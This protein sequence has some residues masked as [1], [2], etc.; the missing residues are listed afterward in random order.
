MVIV[1]QLY[2]WCF[3]R[4]TDSIEDI[5][6]WL[7]KSGFPTVRVLDVT[8]DNMHS[9][10]DAIGQEVAGGVPIVV[11]NLCDGLE[12]D[13]YPGLTVVQ[14]LERKGVKFTGATAEFF[15]NTTAKTTMKH[16][17]T[18]K[19]VPTS[20]YLEYTSSTQASDFDTLGGYP[21]IVKPSVSYSSLSIT[22]ASVVWD[23]ASALA[24]AKAVEKEV[25]EGGVF[26]ERFLAGR[27]F[28]ALVLG[29]AQN[30]FHCCPVVERVFEDSLG[31]Y[32]RFLAF[33]R[34][35]DGYTIESTAPTHEKHLYHY[36]LA[37]AELQVE[38]QR[39]AI[40]A[41]AALG[42][43]SYG[44][45]DMRTDTPEAESIFV[46][47]VNSQPAFSFERKS[48]SMAEILHLAELSPTQFL[49]TLIKDAWNR[50]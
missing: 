14:Q 17:F 36:A 16:A 44:R 5:A 37:P 39:V 22:D 34:Y 30:G 20:P 49:T 1:I 23:G 8:L 10:C 24:Q 9:V 48:S 41:Y 2:L 50:K 45:I 25:M 31:T 3:T 43:T 7:K 29:D 18:V 28:T 21:L 40:L 46:L 26:V 33:N 11:L 42:G 35:W 47:E 27:E 19:S 15:S 4:C 6:L 12:S 13:G 38:L 32:E